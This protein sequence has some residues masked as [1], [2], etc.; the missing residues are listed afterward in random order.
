MVDSKSSANNYESSKM[1]IGTIIKNPK[2]LKL[3]F[4][5]IKTK[6][7]CKHAAT[8]LR[9]IIGYVPGQYKSQQMCDNVILENGV[10]IK[11][12]PDTYKNQKICYNAADNYKTQEMLMKQSFTYLSTISSI[13][14]SR[15]L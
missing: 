12:V 8:K 2:M 7:M 14:Y 6:S 1:S 11:F 13:I 5:H 15:M 10:T 4:D 3:V 9:L